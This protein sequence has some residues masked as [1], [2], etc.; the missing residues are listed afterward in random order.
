MPNGADDEEFREYAEGLWRQRR[1]RLWKEAHETPGLGHQFWAMVD[2]DPDMDPELLTDAQVGRL[3]ELLEEV[4]RLRARTSEEESAEQLPTWQERLPAWQETLRQTRAQWKQEWS[5]PEAERKG[6]AE[7][8]MRVVPR[9]KLSRKI[10]AGYYPSRREILLSPSALAPRHIAHELAHANYFEQMPKILWPA[11]ALAHGVAQVASPEYRE[12]VG[13]YAG[14]I[15]FTRISQGRFPLEGYAAAYEHLGRQPERMPWY[16]EPFYG[17]LM[18]EIP[19]VPKG[20][21][22]NWAA[23]LGYWLKD[24][25]EKSTEE[26]RSSWRDWLQSLS[27]QK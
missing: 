21:E 20:W 2:L 25:L 10:I 3:D 11:H 16:M 13:R 5:V 8:P 27:F 23:W 24:K 15:P 18:Y 17:N 12:A 7:Y 4:K 26:A 1:D 14:E 9:G 19:D 22:K 6:W